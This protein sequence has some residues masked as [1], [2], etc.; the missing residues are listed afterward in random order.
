MEL[1]SLSPPGLLGQVEGVWVG[2]AGHFGEK[3][4]ESCPM[5]HQMNLLLF[6]KESELI[7]TNTGKNPA[8][9]TS[10]WLIGAYLRKVGF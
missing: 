7:E 4:G 6:N 9:P 3:L 1:S 10:S 2:E 8:V 5:V